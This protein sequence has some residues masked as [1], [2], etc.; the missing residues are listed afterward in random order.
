MTL[1]IQNAWPSSY[2]VW[3]KSQVPQ[4]IGPI[5]LWRI[6]PSYDTYNL[7]G[8]DYKPTELQLSVPHSAVIDWI[9]YAG[10]RDR[11]IMHYNN[12]VVLDRLLC[13]ML[14]SYVIEVP[15]L[16][17]I[18]AHAPRGKA[19]F[20]IWNIFRAIDLAFQNDTHS[21]NTGSPP[22]FADFTDQ[23]VDVVAK[24]VED[25]FSVYD[26]FA[27]NDRLGS[28]GHAGTEGEDQPSNHS[29]TRTNKQF[30][31]VEIFTTPASVL[32]LSHD[33]RLYASRSWRIDQTLFDKYPELKFDG[34]EDIVAKGRSC[35]I[36]TAPPDGPHEMT[37]GT[38]QRYQ[39]ALMEFS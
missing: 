11:V 3:F 28:P 25:P 16:S 35:R 24:D 14:N 19:Y 34:Y 13:D 10:M 18:I 23:S 12:S 7:L 17:Q 36:P 29:T 38:V 9:P 15:D 37:A 1:F 39:E 31:L 8:K 5:L 30:N 33:V 4:I 26:E 6:S 32:K 21:R 27:L 22:P 20:G 2:S